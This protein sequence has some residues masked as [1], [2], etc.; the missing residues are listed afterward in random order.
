ML[1]QRLKALFLPEGVLLLAA[2]ALV[3]WGAAARPMTP[4][5][6]V[7][8]LVVLVA[9]VLL[10][11]RFRRGRL[12]LG[13]AALVLADRAMVWLAPFDSGAPYAGPVVVRSV[14]ML[15]PMT[16]VVLAFIRER[17]LFTGVGLRRLAVLAVQ[18]AA[19]LIVWLVSGAY[20]EKTAHAFDLALLPANLLAWSPLG[21]PAALVALAALAV[22]IGRTLW[23]PDPESR[24][25]LWA[26]VASLI[27]A[28]VGPAGGR[29]TLHLANAALVLVVAT[30][31]SAYALAYHDEL[32]GLPG[33]RALQEAL[34]GLNGTYTVAMVDVD[35]F[36]QF[37]D[38]HGHD[39]GDQVLRMV[40]TQLGRVGGG[41]CAFRYG[42]E[43]FALLF[44]GTTA[45]D[46]AQHLEAV[47]ESVADAT[48]TLRS[49]RRP[50]RK[51]SAPRARL[52]RTKATRQLAVTV[53]IGAAQSRDSL[54]AEEL[55]KAA[56]KALYGAKEAGRNRVVIAPRSR[57]QS[58]VMMNSGAPSN[59]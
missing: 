54:T 13:L 47:R 41:G 6:R 17:G 7:Y 39:V 31:E 9:G 24:G 20:P 40:A 4:F 57:A 23:H 18:A 42:G 8:P 28:S 3:H 43:E 55:L 22:L 36:K 12:M 30:V 45:D 1:T 25:F 52:A 26:A 21:Q 44:P 10:A 50:K 32:T 51:P 35:H 49:P 37:N 16:L 27:A 5:V 48:F 29:A 46:S 38:T 59:S 14:A 34:A 15:L 11:W 58:L 2:A 53:S 33:R 56:D 19:V